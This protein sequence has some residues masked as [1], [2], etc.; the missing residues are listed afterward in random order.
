MPIRI[1]QVSICWVSLMVMLQTGS[2]PTSWLLGKRS[3]SC[4][5]VCLSPASLF[6]WFSVNTLPNPSHTH[7]LTPVLGNPSME[8][9][10]STPPLATFMYV[11]ITPHS[12]P[13]HC[14]PSPPP[15]IL[16][17]HCFPSSPSILFSFLLFSPLPP[18]PSPSSPL[19]MFISALTLNTLPSS[20]PPLPSDPSSL[21]CILIL[22]HTFPPPPFPYSYLNL[23]FV[24][25]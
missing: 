21:V 10:S 6:L 2:Q 25:V 7:S 13:L 22:P 24:F 12:L 11:L 4:L 1:F 5:S 19:C 15:F 16:F 3:V 18:L 9:A 14:P 20:F 17:L 23:F 8:Y